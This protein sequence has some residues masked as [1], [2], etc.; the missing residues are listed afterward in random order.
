MRL[1]T[2]LPVGAAFIEAAMELGTSNRKVN[3]LRWVPADNLH[4]TACFLGEMPADKLSGIK[5]TIAGIC[6]GFGPMTLALKD[7]CIWPKKKPYMV[8]ALFE[9][10]Q[11]FTAFYRSMERKL[12]GVSADSPVKPHVTLARFKEYSDIRQIRLSSTSF[13]EALEC[14]R[15][16]LFESRLAPEGPAYYPLAEYLLES[17]PVSKS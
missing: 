6:D 11:D 4:I 10:H 17:Q 15:L 16:I 12:T 5:T 2:G 7:I 3:G 9:E 14:N 13:P 1:F 8:W